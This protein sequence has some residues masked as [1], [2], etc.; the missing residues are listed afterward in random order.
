MAGI[1]EKTGLTD[2]E[3]EVMDHLV[4]AVTRYA[5]L[6]VQHPMEM[7]DF[8]DSI[9]RLQDLMAIRVTRRAFPNGWFTREKTRF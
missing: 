1:N 9:H 3:Q 6:E 7:D 4:G 8:M 5:Q 2:K